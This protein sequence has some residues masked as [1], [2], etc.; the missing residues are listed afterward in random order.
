M[1]KNEKLN[2]KYFHDWKLLELHHQQGSSAK[3]KKIQWRPNLNDGA[4]NSY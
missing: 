4:W 2:D 1:I 3:G